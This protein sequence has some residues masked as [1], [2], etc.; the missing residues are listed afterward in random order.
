MIKRNRRNHPLAAI[1]ACGE[2]AT[3]TPTATPLP[4]PTPDIAALVQGA[5]T[6]A[7]AAQ[8]PTGLSAEEIQ[9][10][11]IGFEHP[12]FQALLDE[13]LIT[14]DIG[15]HWALLAEKG[16]FIYDNVMHIPLFEQNAVWPIG[17]DLGRWD[18]MAQ[19]LSLLSR[20]ENA[21]HRQ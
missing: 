5:V 17:P 1:V 8:E 9:G 10:L 18:P 14:Y 13:A 3:P 4:Q 16:R 21:P 12:D 20:W 6:Q 15:A 19:E 11:N 7:L 2:E